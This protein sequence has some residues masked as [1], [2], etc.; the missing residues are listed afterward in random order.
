MK[1]RQDEEYSGELGPTSLRH[2][3]RSGSLWT[4]SGVVAM[5]IA[6]FV[7]NMVLARNLSPAALGTYYLAV[8]LTSTTAILGRLGLDSA[9]VRL[10]AQSQAREDTGATRGLVSR[11]LLYSF[12]GASLLALLL[13][14]S[15]GPWIAKAMLGSRELTT[16]MPLVALWASVEVLRPVFSETFRGFHDL[17]PAIWLGT[18]VQTVLAALGFGLLVVLQDRPDAR[19]ATLTAFSASTITLLFA[20]FSLLKYFRGL[21]PSRH[22]KNSVRPPHHGYPLLTQ[23]T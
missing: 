14:F 6:G 8:S 21:G 19:A 23:G 5:L 15:G 18:P 3:F 4:L 2:R 10:V 22:L 11:L 12:A 1:P 9:A 7:A 17:R 16:F 20:A 13:W